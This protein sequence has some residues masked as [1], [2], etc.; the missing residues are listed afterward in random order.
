MQRTA[1]QM[2]DPFHPRERDPLA[3]AHYRV[4]T[5]PSGMP[6][7]LGAG[8]MGITY[9]AI[10]TKLLMEVAL[11]VI[12]PSRLE[13]PKVER[14][15]VREARAA[16]RVS[17]ANV[18][19][20]VFLN[21][22]PG[23]FFYA[24]EFVDGVSLYG[25]LQQ[26]KPL[27]P[28]RALAFAEQIARGLEAIHEQQIIHRDLKPAN[29]MVLQFAPEH[30]R[31]RTH[32][33]AGGCLLKII[34]FGLAKGVGNDLGGGA[35]ASTIGFRGTADYASPEQCDERRDLDGRSDIYSLGCMLWEM[36]V[37]TPPFQ[38]KNPHRLMTMHIESP[39]PVE[40]LAGHS[41][42]VVSLLLSSLAKERQDRPPDATAVRQAIEA[43]RAEMS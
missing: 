40:Q 8:G 25:L 32:A 28:A 29:V 9:K 30:P 7:M 41:P 20:V 19:P 16:A 5:K 15:F 21:D 37:G 39:V 2:T 23:R 26:E 18:A 31:Y 27:P 36:L 11:K 10:D 43:A 14:L 42:A 24:M 22:T 3:Y 12:H 1:G 17:H 6:W 35:G 13:D 34:D 4:L 38:A 33:A